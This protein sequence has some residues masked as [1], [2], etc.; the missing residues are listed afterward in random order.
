MKLTFNK[1]MTTEMRTIRLLIL[2]GLLFLFAQASLGQDS[3]P[4]RK[5]LKNICMAMD[6]RT[7]TP[8]QSMFLY[9][10]KILDASCVLPVDTEK[11]QGEKI[12]KMWD[13]YGA[14]LSCTSPSFDVINGNLIKYAVSLTFDAFIADVA[15]WRVDLNKV[16]E[17]DDRTVL[18]Y[19]DLKLQQNRGNS[20]V[21]RLQAYSDILK[22]G[23]AKRKSE[24]P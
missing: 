17:N 9:K 3:C 20:L 8:D 14:D 7:K 6:A 4:N 21:T 18:D 19:L 1:R 13:V 24:L 10:R 23:G 11:V 5:P 15:M 12:R 22:E 2:L 16:D